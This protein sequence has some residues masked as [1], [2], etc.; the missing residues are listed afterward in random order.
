MGDKMKF[1]KFIYIILAFFFLGLG[2]IGI[3]VP[4]L[5]TT[6]FLLLASFFFAKGSTR[7]HNWFIQTKIY[8]KHLDNFVKNREMTL[9]TKFFIL[10]PASL[11]IIMTL[12]FMKNL[13]GR[14]FLMLLLLYKYIYF[15]TK[16]KTIKEKKEKINDSK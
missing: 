4:M 1:L 11:M 3:V 7:F 9:K 15:F 14:I 2:I 8:K 16:I 6:P 5:P 13:H 12:V 10:I